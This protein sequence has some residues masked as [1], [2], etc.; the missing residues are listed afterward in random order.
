LKKQYNKV[1]EKE[2]KLIQLFKVSRI[3]FWKQNKSYFKFFS[4][5]PSLLID[6]PKY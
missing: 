2:R 3:A 1:V 5:F 6:F 4:Q